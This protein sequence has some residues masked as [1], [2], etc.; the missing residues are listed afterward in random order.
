MAGIPMNEE[1][2]LSL[3]CRVWLLEKNSIINYQQ[4]KSPMSPF[5]KGG[6]G[7][8]GEVSKYYEFNSTCRRFT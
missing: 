7:G 8:F 6:M 4:A 5:F 2:I 3:F 1:I